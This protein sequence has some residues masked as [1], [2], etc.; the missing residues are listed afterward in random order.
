MKL[1]NDFGRVKEK[2]KYIFLSTLG[3]MLF[4]GNFTYINSLFFSISTLFF[5]LVSSYYF[6][7]K[8]F[9]KFYWCN[10]FYNKTFET[11]QSIKDI[12]SILSFFPIIIIS[13]VC[14][15]QYHDLKMSL[16]FILNWVLMRLLLY[17]SHNDDIEN[18]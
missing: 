11:E 15:I 10:F 17:M 6:L 2:S 18:I 3:H 7:S 5:I 12:F 13:F 1:F 4:I 9:L 14:Y 8:N 16:F